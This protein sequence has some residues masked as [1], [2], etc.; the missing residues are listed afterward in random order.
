MKVVAPLLAILL[1]WGVAV[2]ATA[3]ERTADDL[4]IGPAYARGDSLAVLRPLRVEFTF[5]LVPG[6][7]HVDVDVA[8]P[9]A[10]A[11]RR[12]GGGG[13]R[14]VGDI[15]PT[16]AA[17]LWTW[18]AGALLGEG[19]RAAT[20]ARVPAAVVAATVVQPQLRWHPVPG[21]GLQA[22]WG[23]EWLL[24]HDE[25]G[26]HWRPGVGV[27]V[28]PLG[29][30]VLE[31]GVQRSLWWSFE[32]RSGDWGWCWFAGVRVRPELR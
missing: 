25:T 31:G 15:V 22:G 14:L 23:G 1:A 21:L 16:A 10:F 5:D 6:R 11:D 29:T 7:L 3:G 32:G 30:L 13:A 20:V 8:A 17:G 12:P 4:A 19:S 28:R 26:Y 18:A 24:F 27:A 9:L 2:P